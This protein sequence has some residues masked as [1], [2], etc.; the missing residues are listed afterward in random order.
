M[1]KFKR[2]IVQNILQNMKYISDDYTYSNNKIYCNI[3]RVLANRDYVMLYPKLHYSVLFREV[4][5]CY[6]E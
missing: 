1:C 3:G 2:C 4:S 5:D 6:V